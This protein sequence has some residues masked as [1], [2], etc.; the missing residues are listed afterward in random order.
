MIDGAAVI[1]PSV[2]ANY[3]SISG[4]T[5]IGHDGTQWIILS[6]VGE[7]GKTGL[8]GSQLFD[9]CRQVGCTNAL[10]MDGGSSVFLQVD[11]ETIINTSR[12]I[13][14]AFLIYGK[15]E[16]EPLGLK[17]KVVKQSLA[18]R[19]SLSFVKQE[20]TDKCPF[21]G[22]NHT[23]IRHVANGEPLVVN[24]EVFT[25]KP[26]ES[27]ELAAFLPELQLDGWQW[28]KVRYNG[29][30]YYAQYDSMAYAIETL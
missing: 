30:I 27:V 9:L 2:V 1:N 11:N 26:G 5:L 8:K 20:W 3:T 6:F 22:V 15:N 10:C 24:G 12:W 7:T 4:R 18:L 23:T 17:I 25:F 14:N 28:V 19:K 29:V 13:K 21:T 16:L